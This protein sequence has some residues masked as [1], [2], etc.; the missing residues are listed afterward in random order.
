MKKFPSSF[1]ASLLALACVLAGHSAA[2]AQINSTLVLTDAG[3]GNPTFNSID[4]MELRGSGLFWWKYGAPTVEFGYTPTVGIKSSLSP[5][6][7]QPD[8]NAPFYMVQGGSF[9]AGVERDGTFA[10]FTA[11]R[12]GTQVGLFR[13]PLASPINATP[14]RLVGLASAPEISTGAIGRL[15]R[16]LYFAPTYSSG[17]TQIYR[18]S[19]DEAGNF[20]GS[21]V[22][23]AQ[24]TLHAFPVRKILFLNATIGGTTG[25]YG[26][27]LQADNS[28]WRFG[29]LPSGSITPIS[30]LGGGVGDVGVRRDDGGTAFNGLSDKIYATTSPTNGGPVGKLV[31][32]NPANG[33]VTEIYADP[34][35]QKFLAF[36]FDN[37]FFYLSRTTSSTGEILR[38]FTPYLSYLPNP[39]PLGSTGWVLAETVS[40]TNLRSDGDWVYFTRGNEIRRMGAAVAPPVLDLAAFGIEAVQTVQDF[41]NSVPLVEGKPVRVRAYARIAANSN[42]ALPSRQPAATLVARRNGVIFNTYHPLKATTITAL[43]TTDKDLDMPLE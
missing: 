22:V 24:G 28:L 3:G 30:L 13:Q 8:H 2:V 1:A 20:S 10:Y 4:R 26:L 19:F 34:A 15:G 31:T 7:G 40:G 12:G 23:I 33:A 5:Y 36:G 14:E 27:C 6:A 21:G 43:E 32:I 18:V 29:P 35:G 25:T 37:N 9:P 11:N 16:D 42:P 17:F 38:K 41:N 39:D